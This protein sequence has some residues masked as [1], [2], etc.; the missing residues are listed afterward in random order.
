MGVLAQ[1]LHK[2]A[3]PLIKISMVLLSIII[4]QVSS[5]TPSPP[6]A[7]MIF[8]YQLNQICFTNQTHALQRVSCF[9]FLVRIESFIFLGH[10]FY[11][12]PLSLYTFMTVNRPKYG[13]YTFLALFTDD[14]F[15]GLFTLINRI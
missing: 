2:N 6:L 10:T 3:T 12:P 13:S 9:L 14:P 4:E 5:H 11:F 1:T 8:A 7:L 15:L